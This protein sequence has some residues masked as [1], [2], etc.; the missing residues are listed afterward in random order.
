MQSTINP[1][2]GS[3]VK[4]VIDIDESELEPAINA[5]ITK[6]SKEVRIPGFRQGKVPRK[7]LEA[8]LGH[9]YIRAEA[10]NGAIPDFIGQAIKSNDLDVI[11]TKAV[12]V[13]SGQESGPVVLEANVEIRPEVNIP[14]YKGVKVVIPSPVVTEQDVQDQIKRLREQFGQLE[15]VNRLIVEDDQISIDVRAEK[16]GEPVS[17]LSVEDFLYRVG[18]E[19]FLPGLDEAVLG[20]S[21]ND[22]VSLEIPAPE[23]SDGG[24]ITCEVTVKKVSQLLLPDLTDEWASEASEF[25]TLAELEDSIRDQVETSKRT[26]S[27]MLFRDRALSALVELIDLEE[28]PSVLVQSEYEQLVHN[29]SHRLEEQGIPLEQ[30]LQVTGT[31]SDQLVSQLLNDAQGQAKVDLALRAL[32]REENILVAEE[33]LQKEIEAYAE[34]SGLSVD[35]FRARITENDQIKIVELEMAKAKA[36]NQFLDEVEIVDEEGNSISRDL[37]F[38]KE[39]EEKQDSSEGQSRDNDKVSNSVGGDSSEGV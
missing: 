29:F 5:A 34:S 15:E 25:E 14:G 30:Y 16:D 9:S 7:V 33:D 17:G 21:V 18:A 27:Q 3:I 19:S 37:L 23:G 20:H 22:V 12:D 10:L 35:E 36:L 2:E 28:I 38:P 32:V 26:R 13:T 8:K 39:S 24:P 11:A 31:T 4:I 1:E 6:I